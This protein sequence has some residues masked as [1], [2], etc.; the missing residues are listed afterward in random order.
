MPQ[1]LDLTSFRALQKADLHVHLNGL[2]SFDLVKTILEE[3]NTILPPGIRIPE[4]LI[5]TQPSSLKNYLKAWD[6]LR[7]IPTNRS[8]L[9][10]LVDSAFRFLHDDNIYLTE[11]RNSILYLALINDVQVDRALA[12]LIE[13]MECAAEKYNIRFGLIMSIPRGEYATDHFNALI[14]AYKKLGCPKA[15]I[16]IDLSGNEDFI[17][18]LYFGDYFR[19]AKEELGLHV[20]IHAGETGSTQNIINAVDLFHADRIGHGTAAA[21]D[22]ELMAMLRE[23]NICLEVCPISNRLTGAVP[24]GSPHPLID[25]IAHKVPFVICSDNPQIHQATL[26]ED[27]LYAQSKAPGLI[28][29]AKL[30]N[31]AE[32]FRFI[33]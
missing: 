6:I 29:F 17:L 12:W 18:P 10:L 21:K 5:K 4:D 14:R 13:D 33:R 24:D 2:V 15:V 8:N 31:H 27:Y 23:K 30:T 7:L 28:D 11:I 16:G 19:R 9:S 25:F 32:S 3:E 1:L 20:T 22:P 26:S